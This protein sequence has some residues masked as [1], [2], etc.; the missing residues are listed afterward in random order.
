MP[1]YGQLR[2]VVEENRV[3]KW[4]GGIAIPNG[5]C[6]EAQGRLQYQFAVSKVFRPDLTDDK[7][8]PA[9]AIRLYDLLYENVP[10]G[11]LPKLDEVII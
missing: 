3:F 7:E 6:F 4:D 5:E 2:K 8:L 9:E 10:P 11:E 1:T